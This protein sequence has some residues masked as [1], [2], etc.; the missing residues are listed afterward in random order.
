MDLKTGDTRMIIDACVQEGLLR[1]ACAYVLATS[2]HE[3][4]YTVTPIYEHGERAYFDKY[5]P[6]T[7]IGRRLGNTQPG[8]GFRYR[9]RGYVQLTGRANYEKAGR[10]IGVDL[11]NNPD[12]ALDPKIAARILVAGMVSGWFTGKKLSNYI[13][14]QHSDFVNAR[15][16]INGTDRANTIALY[17]QQFDML[18]KI[19]GYGETPAQ[20]A[21]LQPS[22]PAASSAV[23]APQPA[24]PTAAPPAPATPQMIQDK[25]GVVIVTQEGSKPPVITQQTTPSKPADKHALMAGGF[26]IILTAM[27][28]LWHSVTACFHSF[29]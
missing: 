24:T 14:L 26:V 8:D 18:L 9:G 12:L 28:T 17:A 7:P 6:G 2:F 1:N 23:P 27:A 15:R 22:I 13:D 11:V 10:I 21:T 16:I 4:E 3:T 5:E 29:F 25:P 19:E 20:P